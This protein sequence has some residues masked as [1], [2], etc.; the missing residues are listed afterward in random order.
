MNKRSIQYRDTWAAPG[1]QLHA[2]LTDGNKRL[3]DSIYTQCEK[4][5]AKLE[6]RDKPA[7]QVRFGPIDH[8]LKGGP[9]LD[10]TAVRI[11]NA[12][13]PILG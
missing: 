6:G 13:I 8:D 7:L 2:A 3:A 12:P 4:D 9:I 10:P 1:S 5:R 11:M